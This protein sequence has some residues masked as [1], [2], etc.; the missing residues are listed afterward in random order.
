MTG[1]IEITVA[2]GT[3]AARAV[4]AFPD[5]TTA[6]LDRIASFGHR[7]QAQPGDVLITAGRRP[8]PAFVLRA[9]V[10]EVCAVLPGAPEGVVV[11][12][13]HPGSVIAEMAVLTG[14]ASPIE[15]RAQTQVA[16]DVLGEPEVRRLVAT[17]ADLGD[18]LL[19]ALAARREVLR[20]GLVASATRVIGDR[21]RLRDHVTVVLVN[22]IS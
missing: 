21:R 22:P 17:Q 8:V 2:D 3:D 19:R 13:H 5:W 14:Q 9:G 4:Q 20:E 7:G 11:A 10:L 15:V 1:S 18:K 12:R 6:E 16:F